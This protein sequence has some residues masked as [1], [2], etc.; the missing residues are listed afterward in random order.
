MT[1]HA[2]EKQH[3]TKLKGSLHFRRLDPSDPCHVT[4]RLVFTRLTFHNTSF[5]V[6]FTVRTSFRSV[7]QFAGSGSNHESQDAT[8]QELQM[9]EAS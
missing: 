8:S 9:A 2:T 1:D 3:H 5:G 7:E 6:L 4:V